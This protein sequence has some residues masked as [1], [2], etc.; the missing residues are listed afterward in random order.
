M[1]INL[2]EI[3]GAIT[4]ALTAFGGL[5]TWL[6][7]KQ[8]KRLKEAEAKLKEAEAQKAEV[9]VEKA[10]I[11]GKSNEWHIWKEQCE[12]LSEQNKH[13]IERNDQLVKMNAEKEDRHQQDIKDWEERFTNQTTYLRGVQRD[14]TAVLERENAHIRR[15]SQLEKEL[16]HYKMWKCYRE[17][18]GKKEGCGRRKPKQPIPI[19]YIPLDSEGDFCD[20]YRAETIDNE[21]TDKES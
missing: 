12:A 6:Y 19:K 16:N 10:R 7:K 2:I 15:E 9:D 17:D 21:K 5:G 1:E 13:L 8:N 14:Y 4:G 3:L 11:E 20:K 18:N